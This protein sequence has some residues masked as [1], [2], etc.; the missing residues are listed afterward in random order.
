MSVIAFDTEQISAI[1]AA[2]AAHQGEWDA[3]WAG[4]QARLGGV[5]SE[6]LDVLTGAGL[7]ERTARYQQKTALYTQQLAARAQATST[8]AAI[9]EQTGYAMVKAL[10][11]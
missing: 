6:A 1:A 7:Q 9:A 3:I 11:G 8:I 10:S 4:V 2:T 5:V